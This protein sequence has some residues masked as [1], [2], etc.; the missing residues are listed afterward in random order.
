M[1]E[2]RVLAAGL[3]AGLTLERAR[4]ISA[5][6]HIPLV[7]DIIEI[8]HDTGVPRHDA[9][10]ALAD[11]RDE[12]ERRARA[13]RTGSAS[14]RQTSVVLSALPLATAFTA[15]LA[16]FDVVAVLVGSA[17]G[18]FSLAVGLGLSAVAVKWMAV[19]RASIPEPAPH[20]GLVL[21]LAAGIAQTS[22]LT[23]THRQ[24]LSELAQRWSSQ[25]ECELVERHS[26]LSR[27]TGVP[28]AGLLA[29]E[30]RL[31]RERAY[32]TVQHAL[33]LLPGK[34]LLPIGVCLFPAFIV[35]TVIPVVISMVSAN[36][37]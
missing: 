13:V 29:V 17:F 10:T 32:A 4:A 31:S 7:E 9:L 18:W 27:D 1:S 36:L 23:A 30:A 8:A 37:G 33:E 35:T 2:I 15:Q 5:V 22:G 19:I 14:A 3:H 12:S 11:S 16:G 34:L 24:T 25:A 20:T 26:M 28:L 6:G 21:D